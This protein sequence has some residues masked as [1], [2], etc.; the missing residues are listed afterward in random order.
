MWALVFITRDPFTNKNLLLSLVDD[1][2]VTMKDTEGEAATVINAAWALTSICTVH[3]QQT[4]AVLLS[5]DV[6]RHLCG[7]LQTRFPRPL[8]KMEIF[9][10]LCAIL[11]PLVD[12]IQPVLL[13]VPFLIAVLTVL[14]EE[15]E[16]GL[17]K[18]LGELIRH[19]HKSLG[20]A[21][22]NRVM[23]EVGQ[24]NGNALKKKYKL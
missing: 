2:V 24:E 22:W 8:E 15:E 9:R 23:F 7:V 5:V 12:R 3:R 19:V 18:A 21:S 13:W 16:G 11:G 1:L 17:D 20:P 4:V 14:D 10:N 6:F